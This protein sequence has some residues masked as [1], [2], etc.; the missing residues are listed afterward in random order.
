MFNRIKAPIV[1]MLAACLATEAT[2]MQASTLAFSNDQPMDWTADRME[3]SS[4]TGQAFLTGQVTVQQGDLSIK[5]PKIRISYQTGSSG[6][7]VVRQAV[8]SEGVV[9]NRNSQR[10]TGKTAIYDVTQDIITVLGDVVID[11]GKDVL[12]GQRLVLNLTN[13]EI[14]LLGSNKNNGTTG[15]VTGQFKVPDRKK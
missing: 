6:E 9:I 11:R 12:K 5:A 1:V 10:I 7:P 2:G 15:R 4:K 8:A 14:S 3:V 13:Q